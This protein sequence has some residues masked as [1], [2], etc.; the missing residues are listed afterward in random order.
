MRTSHMSRRGSSVHRGG[1]LRVARDERADQVGGERVDRVPPRLGDDEVPGGAEEARPSRSWRVAE[2]SRRRSTGTRVPAGPSSPARPRADPPR[3]GRA[4][5]AT[6]SRA[7]VRCSGP[8]CRGTETGRACTPA[9]RPPGPGRPPPRRWFETVEDGAGQGREVGSSGRGRGHVD[10]HYSAPPAHL[11]DL[12]AWTSPRPSDCGDPMPGWLNT[13]SYGLPPQPAWDALQAALAD[14]RVGRTSWE[15]WDVATQRARESFARLV[16]VD[17]ADVA[18][19]AQ[20]SQLLAP[21]AAAIPDGASVVV[22]EEEFTSN[23]FPWLVQ[24]DRGVRVST[25]PALEG[26]GGHPAG[27]RRGRVQPGPV[28]DGRGGGRTRRSSRRPGPAGR[29]S[30]S[31]PPRRA[32]GCRSTPRWPTWSSSGAYKWLMS[33]RGTAFRVPRA[34]RCASGCGRS[35]PAGTRERTST[36][37]T[38]ARRCGWRSP[39]AASTSRRPGSAGSPRRRRSSWS[40]RIGV[41]AI[42]DHNVAL[43]NRFLAGLGQPPARQRDRDRRRAGRRGAARR[44][45]RTGS[46]ARRSGPRLVPRLHH[47]ARRRHGPRR[48]RGLMPARPAAGGGRWVDVDPGAPS[49]SGSPASPSGTASARAGPAA[50]RVR[51][52]CRVRPCGWSPPTARSRSCTLRRAR[53]RPLD[54][55]DLVA[56]AHA[57]RRL[58][59]LLARQA[60]VAVGVAE[61]EQA[62]S[63][64]GGLVLCA[65][66]HRG[67][68]MVAAS[69]RAPAGEPGE[70]GGGRRRRH[71]GPAAAARGRRL[72]AVVTGGDRRAVD[73]VLSDPRLAPVA[74]LRSERFLD[75]PE[76]RL[77]VLQRAVAAARAVRVRM[78]DAQPYDA[79]AR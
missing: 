37:R 36:R 63:V 18:V 15:V 51:P 32:A 11:A 33:P 71:R 56:A 79:P 12:P 68:W 26:G 76:P 21:V 45:G 40:R 28:G 23:L 38:T 14:W 3:P 24:A 49:P 47:R 59:L 17:A 5:P 6:T 62:R 60:A 66:T 70:G 8:G 10:Q 2:A 73:A 55:D 19:G 52:R 4:S 72:A 64:Q 42:H 69:V 1:Q 34:R 27:Y 9:S 31:T 13:A 74:A 39:R 54:L 43:A 22:P 25:V 75:V 61:G 50:V 46:G 53:R 65:G 7:S 35:R 58:G 16:G 48:A 41:G 77:A 20:V 29:W 78:R 30:S 44:G 67:R 57:P